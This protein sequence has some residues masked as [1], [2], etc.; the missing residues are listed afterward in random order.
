MRRRLLFILLF[1]CRNV[2]GG[3]YALPSSRGKGDLPA[4]WGGEKA[5][6]RREA[7]AALNKPA[8]VFLSWSP[9]IVLVREF[10]TEEE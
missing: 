3:R 6:A 10:L 9:R 1:V 8:P 5:L 4:G 7:V 2:V